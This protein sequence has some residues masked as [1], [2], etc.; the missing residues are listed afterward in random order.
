MPSEQRTNA[1]KARRALPL[2]ALALLAASGCE[3]PVGPSIP[4]GD[5][6]WIGDVYLLDAGTGEM[7]VW[8]DTVTNG[9]AF[10]PATALYRIEDG[11]VP[12][13]VEEALAAGRVFLQDAD[14]T[15][16]CRFP[17][18]AFSCP[19]MTE[20][21]A[22]DRAHL[23]VVYNRGSCRASRG[24]YDLRVVLRDRE[25]EPTYLGPLSQSDRL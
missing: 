18:P 5:P 6:S 10:D 11:T 16:E 4:C 21:L 14:D 7:I 2:C 8:V 15:Y 9:S 12:T 1:M 3:S 23:L 20:F 22:F 25:V 24:Y 19:R 13:T 17:P